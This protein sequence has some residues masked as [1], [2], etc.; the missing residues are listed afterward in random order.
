[1][2]GRGI[3]SRKERR[4]SMSGKGRRRREYRFQYRTSLD[5]NAR[6][7]YCHNSF[8]TILHFSPGT[9]VPWGVNAGGG[10]PVTKTV[11]QYIKTGG[12]YPPLSQMPGEDKQGDQKNPNPNNTSGHAV[13]IPPSLTLGGGVRG[14]QIRYTETVGQ[15]VHISPPSLMPGRGVGGDQ[16]GTPTYQDLGYISFPP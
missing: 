15:G 5:G 8:P 16:K 13:H 11:H 9:A 3:Y 6:T 7:A 10:G 2:A 14:E 12:R 4:S 1:M